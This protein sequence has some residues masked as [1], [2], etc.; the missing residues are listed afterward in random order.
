MLKAGYNPGEIKNLL[1]TLSLIKELGINDA[2]RN[3]FFNKFSSFLPE[4]ESKIYNIGKYNNLKIRVEEYKKQ[5]E[6][7]IFGDNPEEGVLK[8]NTFKHQSLHFAITYPAGWE[9]ENRQKEIWVKHETQDFFIQ[10][11]FYNLDK[12]TLTGNVAK[13]VAKKLHLNLIYGKETKINGW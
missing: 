4:I 9:I 10:I 3:V 6:N 5:I 7:L 8:N 2:K 13:K 1:K 11:T 12:Y